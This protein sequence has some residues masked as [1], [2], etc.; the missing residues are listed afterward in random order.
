MDW[1]G[2]GVRVEGGTGKGARCRLPIEFRGE[3]ELDAESEDGYVH[4][5]RL[6]V[7]TDTKAL[8][9]A[10]SRVRFREERWAGKLCN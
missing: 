2:R 3:L 6:Q 9:V 5:A 7:E 10:T 1:V 4:W 8:S